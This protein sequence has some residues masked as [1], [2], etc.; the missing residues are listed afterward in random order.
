[1]TSSTDICNIALGMLGADRITGFDNPQ[2]SNE[3]LCKTFYP[4]VRDFMLEQRDWSFLMTRA[5]LNTPD[6]A[7]PDWGFSKQHSLPFDCYRIIDARKDN[8]NN[9]PSS[10]QWRREKNNILCDSDVVF[11]RYL[12]SEIPSNEY[13]SSFVMSLAT[14]L[15]AF[16][17]VQITENRTLK[18][19][20]I[21]EA[22]ALLL[23]AAA[24]DGMQGKHEQLHCSSLVNVRQGGR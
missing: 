6:I 8:S 10:F 11:I 24:T 15:A 9:G 19:D 20:L 14:R 12:S 21:G 3:Q 5:V 13:S 17:C 22:E 7:L 2:T 4:V 18:V 23:D 16:M 1:M